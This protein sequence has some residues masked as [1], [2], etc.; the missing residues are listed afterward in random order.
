MCETETQP[1]IRPSCLPGASPPAARRVGKRQEP[2]LSNF[3]PRSFQRSASPALDRGSSCFMSKAL[4]RAGSR[5]S[6]EAH[7]KS[8]LDSN[9]QT[10]HKKSLSVLLYRPIAVVSEQHRLFPLTCLPSR[11]TLTRAC[12][13][14]RAA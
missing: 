4:Q 11:I 9:Y 7:S 13:F 8:D 10:L 14:S 5:E 2:F 12:F 3:S 6:V 1:L